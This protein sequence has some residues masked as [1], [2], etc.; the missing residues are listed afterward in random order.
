[1]KKYNEHD[2]NTSQDTLSI[3]KQEQSN[4]NEPSIFENRNTTHPTNTEKTL[5]EEQKNKS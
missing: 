4:R 3:D 1:M 5:T 2:G